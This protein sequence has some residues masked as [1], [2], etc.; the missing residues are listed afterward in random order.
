MTAKERYLCFYYKIVD[1]IT[2]IASCLTNILD[3]TFYC[4]NGCD[5]T[6]ADM[7]INKSMQENS[8]I[9]N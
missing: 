1:H 5:N 6:C 9:R 7:I 8:E 2:P 3:L 4:H